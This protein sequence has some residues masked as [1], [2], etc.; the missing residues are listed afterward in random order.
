[1]FLIRPLFREEGRDWDIFC[2]FLVDLKKKNI[3]RFPDL[4]KCLLPRKM[5]FGF[6]FCQEKKVIKLT[7]YFKL[8]F[9]VHIV[10]LL[11]SSQIQKY[12]LSIKVSKRDIKDALHWYQVSFGPFLGKIHI[13]QIVSQLTMGANNFLK[14]YQ[15]YE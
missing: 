10:K 1:M 15:S 6:F 9:T 12:F 14:N 4:Q 13:V 8:D 2:C 5:N 7:T 3:L 11:F